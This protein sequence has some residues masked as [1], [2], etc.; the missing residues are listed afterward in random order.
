MAVAFDAGSSNS[1]ASCTS[2]QFNHTC[3][4]SNRG[5]IVGVGFWDPVPDVTGITYNSVAMVDEGQAGTGGLFAQAHLFSLI[6]PATGLNEV[7]ISTSGGS[8]EILGGGASYTGVDQTTMLGAAPSTAT[9]TGTAPSTTVTSETGEMVV[10]VAGL[11]GSG[12]T[13]TADG[14]QTEAWKIDGVSNPIG[15]S[16]YESGASSV[17]MSWTSSAS[18]DWAII[19]A[20]LNAA[21]A[22]VAPIN[23]FVGQ[24]INRASTF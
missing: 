13:V 19:A 22:V 9:G 8:I 7:D 4:G 11:D 21:A 17:T 5:L 10:D 16:S 24:A 18:I 20:P 12:G 3:T 14:G 6:A 23:I 2:L 1:C 15:G